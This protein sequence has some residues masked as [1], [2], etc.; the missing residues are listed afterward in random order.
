MEAFNSNNDPWQPLVS[1]GS[2]NKPQCKG[3]KQNAMEEVF[4]C[5]VKSFLYRHTINLL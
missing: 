3:T 4:V 5:G 2:L 1:R